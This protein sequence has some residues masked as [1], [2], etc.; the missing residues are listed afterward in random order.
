[1]SSMHD[2]ILLKAKLI[3]VAKSSLQEI[4]GDSEMTE[5]DAKLIQ[6]FAMNQLSQIEFQERELMREQMNHGR[7][8]M[9]PMGFDDY[10]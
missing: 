2:P 7:N 9:R 3:V 8:N 4:I 5:N 10:E 6:I 1:M